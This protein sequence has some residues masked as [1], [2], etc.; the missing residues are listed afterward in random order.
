MKLEEEIERIEEELRKTP[1]NKATEAHIGRLKA[2]LAKLRKEREAARGKTR[3]KGIRKDGDATVAIVGF[4]SSG[5]STLLN[6]LTNAN[7]KVAP[8]DFTTTEIIPAS[9][10][11]SGAK[12]Q[13]LDLPGIIEG[14]SEGKGRG[15][16]VLS[17]VRM[18]DLL[19]V[20]IDALKPY[21]LD[22][23]KRELYN[24]GIRLNK[25]PPDVVVDIRERGGIYVSKV[26]G[27]GIS[28]E[29][30]R[31]IL[32]ERRIFN[33]EV[34]IREDISVEEFI[35][36]VE[37]N[38]KYVPAIFALNKIDLLEE[39]PESDEMIPISAK[40][41]KNIERLK[42]MIFEKLGFI[43]VYPKP[44]DGEIEGVLLLKNGATVKDACE[45]IHRDLVKKF[46]F[47]RI[48]GR[49]V[50]FDSQRVGLDHRLAN[51]DI[52]SIFKKR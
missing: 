19:I 50:K 51:G 43:R 47:A 27:V 33:A 7:S 13:I 34:M 17:A 37:G 49:S 26:K 2:K 44:P 1:Y 3:K 35:D 11:V 39:V 10:E 12:I 5:K 38:R 20:L 21:Q 4:P 16:E 32:R 15:K 25:K 18:A 42:S 14:A 29:V 52:V 48:W 23:I 9:F 28:E 6:A 30:I 24:A 36:V 22:I 41:G 31:E 46:R 8:Y 40:E 45:K